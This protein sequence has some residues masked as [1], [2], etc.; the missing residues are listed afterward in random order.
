MASKSRSST[1]FLWEVLSRSLGIEHPSQ[2]NRSAVE[3]EGPCDGAPRVQATLDG[4]ADMSNNNNNNNIN[5]SI[6]NNNNSVSKKCQTEKGRS[7]Q[8]AATKGPKQSRC[9]ISRLSDRKKPQTKGPCECH[10]FSRFRRSSH[11]AQ[12]RLTRRPTLRLNSKSTTRGPT[13]PASISS[14]KNSNKAPSKT[15]TKTRTTK[16]QFSASSECILSPGIVRYTF[17]KPGKKEQRRLRRLAERGRLY[18]LRHG[19]ELPEEYLERTPTSLVSELNRC[20]QQRR[21]EKR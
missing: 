17:A 6:N 5:N 3:R 20:E 18:M 9:T 10:R 14:T 19:R 2:S 7:Q 4:V 13:A 8:A 21:S 1:E 11:A 15:P 16:V 12:S